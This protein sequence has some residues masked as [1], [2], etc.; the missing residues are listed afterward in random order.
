MSD[1]RASVIIPC[2]QQARLLR[3]CLAGLARERQGDGFETIVVDSGCDAATVSATSGLAGVHIIAS[4]G[5]LWPG[6]ARNLGARTAR[7]E[8][9]LFLDADCVPEPGWVSAGEAGLQGGARIVVGPVLDLLPRHPI[10]AS[11]NLLQFAE[12]GPGRPEGPATRLPS[13]NFAIRRSDF[14]ALGGFADIRAGEDTLLSRVAL[15]RWPDGLR[16]LPAMRVRHLGR[17]GLQAFF[18]HQ[19]WFGYSRGQLRNDLTV[20][21]QRV[22]ASLVML[23]AVVVKRLSYILGRTA[24]WDPRRLPRAFG[25]SPLL[26]AGLVAYAI[27]L[28]RGLRGGP[29]PGEPW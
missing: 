5:R 21:Q 22:A 26:V 3:S 4:G 7:G 13:C 28:R 15:S 12:C 23:P 1:P 11:D 10:A 9:L 25:L 27:G 14:D 19:T 8:F 24:M 17:T 29:E 6:A 20:R 18:A 2:Y 16:F